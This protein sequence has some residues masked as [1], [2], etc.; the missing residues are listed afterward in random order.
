MLE[1]PH[2]TQPPPATKTPQLESFPRSISAA[3]CCPSS[4]SPPSTGLFISL[5]HGGRKS[6]PKAQE[7][8]FH[9]P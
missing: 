6:N 7:E 5:H 3:H 1:V 2:V 9:F 8:K 4:N